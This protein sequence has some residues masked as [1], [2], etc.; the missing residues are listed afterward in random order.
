MFLTSEQLHELTGYRKPALQR[1]W[2][3]QNGYRFDV[4]SDGRPALLEAQV[5]A[6]QLKGLGAIA[7]GPEEPDL[8]ALDRIG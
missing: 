5:R 3:L 2:L 7:D 6:R 8:D 4:R 1:H